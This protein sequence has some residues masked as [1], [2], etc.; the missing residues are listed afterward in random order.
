MDVDE[1]DGGEGGEEEEDGTVERKGVNK[2]NSI[3]QY[4]H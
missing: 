3:V 2:S 4:R 1:D